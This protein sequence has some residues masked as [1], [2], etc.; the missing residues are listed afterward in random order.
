MPPVDMIHEVPD[1]VRDV[2]FRGFLRPEPLRGLDILV[3]D[4]RALEEFESLR[5]R[6]IERR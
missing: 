6:E 4:E 3:M 5:V 1:D 2:L